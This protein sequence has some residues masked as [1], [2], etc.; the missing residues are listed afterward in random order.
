MSLQHLITPLISSLLTSPGLRGL[1]RAGR[2]G[3]RRLAGRPRQADCYLRLDDPWSWLLAQTLPDFAAH[4]DLQL[5]PHTL[6]WLPEEMYPEPEMLASLAPLDAQ[7]LAAFYGLEFPAN[8]QLPGQADV[9]A[10]TRVLLSLENTPAYWPVFHE[11]ASALWQGE[12]SQLQRLMEQHGAADETDARRILG[13]RRD[14]FLR[15][16][17]Y[18]SAT[19]HYAGEWY[20]SID[21]LDHLATRLHESGA[22]VGPPP[23]DYGRA[24][25]LATAPPPAVKASPS[26]PLTL[27]FSFRSPYSWLALERTFALADRYALDLD[28]RPVLPMVMRGLKV[29]TAKR[30]YILRDAAREAA[31]HQVP[32]G[33]V[34]DPLGTGVERC[35]AIWPYAEQQGRLREWLLAAGEGIWS[36]GVNVAADRGLRRLVEQAG[37]DWQT[38]QSWLHDDGWREQAEHNR[39]A[40]MAAGSWGVPTLVLDNQVIWGQDRFALLE[41]ACS[42]T[43]PNQDEDPES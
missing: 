7:R 25:Y 41:V 29:P 21:R 26:R 10:A 28:I 32:F 8:W 23:M 1:N 39:A 9:L 42:D 31:L 34:C 19:V 4:F 18:L 36:Q 24:K 15:T 20:W 16:G 2:E 17:H 11:L 6:L 37:L 12:G 14:S 40:M 30:F 3:L 35:M 33:R 38:A 22:G 5:S 27:Y 43:H 13:E